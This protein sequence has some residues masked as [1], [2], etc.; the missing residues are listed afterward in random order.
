MT[1]VLRIVG[2]GLVIA[3]IAVLAG[4]GWM[5]S[6]V[7]ASKPALDGEIELEGLIGEAVVARD[8][9]GVPH[10]FA[11]AD[12]DVFF[13]LGYVHADERFF[14]MDLARRYVH[15]R[16]AELFGPV[17]VRSDARVRTRGFPAATEAVIANAA[18]DTR[19]AVDAYV[20]GV[21]ARLAE[22]RP[23]PEYL[24]LG[25]RP[26]TWTRRDT[27]A[28]TPQAS[29]TSMRAPHLATRFHRRA[30]RSGSRPSRTGR[31]RR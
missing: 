9:N 25:A 29:M 18:P 27:A 1:W 11:D 6:R 17:A 5:W 31:R 2:A 30:W 14:Q 19:A 3:L 23:A 21:N 4:G 8:E 7:Q 12:A 28:I 10:I 16:L 13:A 26:E 22:G 20:A 24:L 15:G